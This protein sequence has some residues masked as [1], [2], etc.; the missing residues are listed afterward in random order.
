MAASFNRVFL[1]GNLTRD[2]ELRYTSNGQAVT[3][4]G[5]AINRRYRDRDDQW[6]E[7]V[8]FVDIDVWGRQAETSSEYL[9]KGRAAFIEG[10]LKLDQ[11][12]DRNTGQR[13]SKLKVVAD[14]VQ[15]LGG[16]GKDEAGDAERQDEPSQGKGRT[17][18]GAGRSREEEEP[19]NPDDDDVPF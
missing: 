4:L 9:R 14:R 17:P 8:T 5:L 18:R 16:R 7:E 2:P 11:W 13:R 10:R 19:F 1:M 3:T 12:E 6:Q 15:F